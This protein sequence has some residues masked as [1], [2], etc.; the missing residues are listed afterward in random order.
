MYNYGNWLFS[1]AGPSASYNRSLLHY[2]GAAS[3]DQPGQLNPALCTCR[4]KKL[5][6]TYHRT[7]TKSETHLEEHRYCINGTRYFPQKSTNL[8]C[9]TWLSKNTPWHFG[10]T[11]QFAFPRYS[12]RVRGTVCGV[13]TISFAFNTL[14]DNS[15]KE[16]GLRAMSCTNC[17]TS[18]LSRR[19]S[20]N[21]R[22]RE[23]EIWIKCWIIIW[24]MCKVLDPQFKTPLFSDKEE[25]N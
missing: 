22:E 12:I 3:N 24:S 20:C 17:T 10:F 6:V 19:L 7:A 5:L 15:N 21:E 2:F 13:T 16:G 9:S 8:I 1:L 18:G 14:A 11:Q 23:G 25:F 4:N